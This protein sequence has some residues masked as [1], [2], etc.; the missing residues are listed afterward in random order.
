MSSKSVKICDRE[1]ADTQT[2]TQTDGDD[3]GD[4]L[5]SYNLSHAMGQI[6]Q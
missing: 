3:R 6:I 4:P 2:H 5:W 1:S